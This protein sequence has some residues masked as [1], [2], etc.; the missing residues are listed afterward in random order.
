MRTIKNFLKVLHLERLDSLKCN[1]S[2]SNV[3]FSVER[4]DYSFFY[5]YKLNTI[6]KNLTIS[7][8]TGIVN[9]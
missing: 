1:L 8:R 6:T 7:G 3:Y 4:Q 2:E 9:L 5:F